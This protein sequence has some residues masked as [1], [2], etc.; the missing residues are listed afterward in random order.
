ML[1]FL[2]FMPG[3]CTAKMNQNYGLTI[4]AENIQQ[5]EDNQTRFYVLTDGPADLS[6]EGERMVFSA[7][8]AADDLP[9]LLKRMAQEDMPLISIHDRP[10]K[11]RLGQYI[12]L[13]E[14]ENSN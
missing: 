9:E 10:E 13:I 3:G 14:C 7:T 4:L 11:T 8:G 12:Y 5:N 6:A 1:I 2:M